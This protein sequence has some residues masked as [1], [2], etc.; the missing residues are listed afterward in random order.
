[1]L[2]DKLHDGVEVERHAEGMSQ[3]DGARAVRDGR[4][5]LVRIR[6]VVAQTHVHEDR[7]Q[8]VLHDGRHGAGK[9]GRHG[10]DFVAGL[11]PALAELGRRQRREGH[12]IGRRAGVDEQGVGNVEVVGHAGLELLREPAG[13]EVEVQA[14]VDEAP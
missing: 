12:Q 13:R 6:V 10:D 11:E 4:A 14:R 5:Q 2:F 9:A 1:M 3:H 7:H 8:P